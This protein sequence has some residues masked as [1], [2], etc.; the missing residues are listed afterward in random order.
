MIMLL[1]REFQSC[2]MTALYKK[3]AKG[4]YPDAAMFALLEARYLLFGL[5][6]P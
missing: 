6:V 5:I 2:S 3:S 1:P 4:K